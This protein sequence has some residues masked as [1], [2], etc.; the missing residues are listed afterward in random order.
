MFL[1]N[2]P[3]MFFF[4]THNYS[5]H[6]PA[7]QPRHTKTKENRKLI[8]AATKEV[9]DAIICNTRSLKNLALTTGSNNR[10]LIINHLHPIQKI[11][12]ALCP[13]N[14]RGSK[15]MVP[16][17]IWQSDLQVDHKPRSSDLH[18][19]TRQTSLHRGPLQ[20]TRVDLQEQRCSPRKRE[21][22]NLIWGFRED[23]YKHNCSPL[24]FH[25]YVKK[26]VHDIKWGNKIKN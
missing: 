23:C 22:N 21:T 26:F 25:A 20:F 8:D 11:H 13:A 24:K 12:H 15:K 4:L 3:S 1:L 10:L 5:F 16:L 18:Q 9:Q 7:N 6:F 2:F 14:A 19:V 17:L